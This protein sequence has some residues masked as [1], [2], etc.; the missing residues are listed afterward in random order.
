MTRLVAGLAV[1]ASLAFGAQ[2][3]RAAAP[4]AAADAT[5]DVASV[6]PATTDSTN[7]LSMLPRLLPPLGGRFSAGNVTLR[8]VLR[9]AHDLQDFQIS[10]GPSWLNTKRFDIQA[11][12]PEGFTGGL[13]EMQPMIRALL[14]ERF[15]LKTHIE[16]REMP[17]S[18]LVVARS[19]GRLGPD[20]KPSTA[21]CPDPQAQAQRSAE[22]LA[23]GDMAAMMAMLREHPECSVGPI[24]PARGSMTMGIKANGQPISVIAGFVQQSTGRM[25]QDRTGLTGLYDFEL[26]LDMQAMVAMASQLGVTAPA[27][28]NLPPSNGPSLLTALQEQ[29]G[30]KIN[31]ERGFVDVL[32]IDSAEEPTPN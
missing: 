11:K 24:M 13:K 22:M 30:L 7:P 12:A 8:L 19:D 28:L 25:V 10:G 4:Q 23:K 3:I 6:K 2:G 9:M 20:L 18:V 31:T 14:A 16:K 29:L 17:I 15:A 1:A 21:T 5:F 26:Q 32:V 27:G